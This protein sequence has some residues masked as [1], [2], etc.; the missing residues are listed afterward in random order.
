MHAN[1]CDFV[2][3]IIPP[4]FGSVTLATR[5]SSLSLAI[6]RVHHRVGAPARRRSGRRARADSTIQGCHP[7]NRCAPSPGILQPPR[8][9]QSHPPAFPTAR[10]RPAHAT[11][12]IDAPWQR[13]AF[14]QLSPHRADQDLQLHA[15]EHSECRLHAILQPHI[16]IRAYCHRPLPPLALRRPLGQQMVLVAP[17]KRHLVELAGRGMRQ[18]LHHHDRIRQPP[19]GDRP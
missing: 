6:A 5:D 12:A 7:G 8:Y 4:L 18:L 16:R 17:A 14:G 13:Q 9:W 15:G 19:S 2:T 1:H 11:I 3:R 10:T